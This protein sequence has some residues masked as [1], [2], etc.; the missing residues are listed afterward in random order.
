MA[1]DHCDVRPLTFTHETFICMLSADDRIKRKFQIQDRWL[2]NYIFRDTTDKMEKQTANFNSFQLLRPNTATDDSFITKNRNS[3]VSSFWW[4]IYIESLLWIRNILHLC[5]TY[6]IQ[7][8]RV[9]KNIQKC[10]VNSCNNYIPF[11]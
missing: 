4:Q 9:I 3:L 2:Q 6:A 5:H 7:L 10:S 1:C 8:W 11:T